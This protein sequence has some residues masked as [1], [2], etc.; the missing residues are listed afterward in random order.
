MLVHPYD[1]N[2][3]GCVPVPSLLPPSLP[4]T[5]LADKPRAWL[6]I[7]P[8]HPLSYHSCCQWNNNN[9]DKIVEMSDTVEGGYHFV[10][11]LVLMLKLV[12]VRSMRHV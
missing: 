3:D 5:P 1:P 8:P 10:A 11:S 2:V 4:H 9:N 12:Y 7:Y 6:N